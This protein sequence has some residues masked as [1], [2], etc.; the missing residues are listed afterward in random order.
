MAALQY[1]DLPGYAALIL[2][3]TYTQLQKPGALMDRATEWLKGTDAKWR[4]DPHMW[5]FPSGS[6]LSFGFIATENDKYNFDSAEY[7]FVG[8]D[9]VTQF[10]ES[11][12]R[13]LFSRMRK[14]HNSIL[15]IRM[16]GAGMP[17]N[18]GHEWVK[19]RFIV[20]GLKYGRSYIGAKLQDNPHINRC[21]YTKGL[22]QLDPITRRMILDGDWS[23]RHSGGVFAAE[24]I[25]VVSVP[26][27]GVP[28]VRFWDLAATESKGNNEPDWTAGAKMS[29]GVNG[30]Y[31][32]ED[33]KRKRLTPLGVELLI[34]QTAE[35]DGLETSIYME[36]EPGASGKNTIS[37]YQRNILQR[38]SFA[39][40]RST[41][42]KQARFGPLSS[43]AE[44]GNVCLVS[45]LY[46]NDLL[47][48]LEGLW[49]GAHDD[50][51]DALSGAYLQLAE[52]GEPGVRSL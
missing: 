23:A 52:G 18:I 43:Q 12:Y 16:R 46:V 44:A 36:Q 22:M 5:V 37:H 45:G 6:S 1:V 29:K 3:R 21:E 15:P 47:D 49:G 9:E 41:G 17:G 28:K 14:G 48:E 35:L 10:K 40:V 11:Q 20:E 27:V 25:K 50:Q 33:V 51:A 31:Y 42:D 39:G 24:W 26:P 8:F 32:I 30:I 4:A 34:K 13:Y 19:K 2:R 7:Q 38:F